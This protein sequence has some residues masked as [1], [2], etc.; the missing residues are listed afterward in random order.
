MCDGS[1]Q[2]EYLSR[3]NG[4]TLL[5]VVING[6]FSHIS[7]LP[8]SCSTLIAIVQLRFLNSRIKNITTIG[9]FI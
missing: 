6:S 1:S 3:T 4:N 7:L 5:G 2:K 8:K 9:A